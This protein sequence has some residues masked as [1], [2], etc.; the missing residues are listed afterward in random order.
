MNENGFVPNPLKI[1]EKRPGTVEKFIPYNNHVFENGTLT[2]REK[3]LISLT[4]TISLKAN[5]C[6]QVKIDEAKKA[7]VNEDEIMQTMLIT[8]IIN[9]N[10]MLHT[11]YEAFKD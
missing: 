1:M 3:S 10:T 11:A 6:I 4:A 8:G 7:G 9:G 2:K 5:H